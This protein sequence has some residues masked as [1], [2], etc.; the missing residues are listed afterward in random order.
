[1]SLDNIEEIASFIVADGKGILAADES[2]PTCGKRF[3]SIGKR[4][5]SGCL[6]LQPRAR[7]LA[8]F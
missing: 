8:P 7:V 5:R 4:C 6:P 3:D 1:M 2:N